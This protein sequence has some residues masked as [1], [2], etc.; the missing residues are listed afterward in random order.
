ML[1]EATC[2][3]Q[4]RVLKW[5]KGKLP[6][7]KPTPKPSRSRNRSS[8]RKGFRDPRGPYYEIIPGYWRLVFRISYG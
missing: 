2:Y 3:E 6:H 7:T 1:T 4:G 8:E 5:V